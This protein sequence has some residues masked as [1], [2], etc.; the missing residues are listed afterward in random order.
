MARGLLTK[1]EVFL[2]EYVS[3]TTKRSMNQTTFLFKLCDYDFNKLM[4]LEEKLK[5]TF[6]HYCPSDIN[7]VEEVLSSKCLS[8][9]WK[10]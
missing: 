3:N 1:H 6:A 2:L 8:E 9:Y 10:F 7:E 5:N 4:E